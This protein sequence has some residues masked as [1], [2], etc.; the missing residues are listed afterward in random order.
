MGVEI[1]DEPAYITR[2]SKRALTASIRQQLHCNTSCTGWCVSEAFAIACADPGM[3]CQRGS[4]FDKVFFF[5]LDEGREDKKWR[6]AGVP[7]M[8]QH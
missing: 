8:A 7:M 4:N 2:R 6:F 5:L 3:F 1:S